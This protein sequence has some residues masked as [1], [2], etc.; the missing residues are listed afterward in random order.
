MMPIISVV[1]TWCTMVV[2]TSTAS[3]VKV[4]VSWQEVSKDENDKDRNNNEEISFDLQYPL[5]AGGCALVSFFLPAVIPPP[6]RNEP[7]HNKEPIPPLKRQAKQSFAFFQSVHVLDIRSERV[8]H[9]CIEAV[10]LGQRFK[11]TMKT[12][13]DPPVV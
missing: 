1:V 7:D 6:D 5:V 3:C 11:S 9:Q 2:V 13:V 8:I 10:L 4:E 12:R